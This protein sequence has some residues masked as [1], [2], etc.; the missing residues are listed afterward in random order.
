MMQMID[1]SESSDILVDVVTF[2]NMLLGRATGGHVEGQEY[3]ALRRRLLSDPTVASMLPRFVRSCIDIG[4][5]WGYIKSEFGTYEDRRQYLRQQFAPLINLL[6]QGGNA[7]S[8]SLVATA[9]SAV[10]SDYVRD[11]WE[12]AL[13]RRASDPEG[14]ITAART[15]LETVCKHVLDES[16]VT[17]EDSADLPKLYR[18]V[19]ELLNLAP[20]QHS[21]DIFRRILGGCQTVVEGLGALRNRLSDAHGRGRAGMRPDARHAELAVNLAGSMAS[22]IVATWEARVAN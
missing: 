17:Y 1:D 8:D 3:R 11:A 21:E 6:E 19:A 15:L 12:K 13:S 4:D 7:P 2:R 16:G 22:F 18:S 14:A 10:T 5:F 20:S 9:L